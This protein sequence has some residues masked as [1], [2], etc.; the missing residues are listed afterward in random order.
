MRGFQ[1]FDH[2]GRFPP[3][4]RKANGQCRVRR[5][6][7]SAGYGTNCRS[8]QVVSDMEI[9]HF[10]GFFIMARRLLRLFYGV[11]VSDLSEF[12]HAACS[13]RGIGRTGRHKIADDAQTVVF[14]GNRLWSGFDSANRWSLSAAGRDEAGHG[15][16]ERTANI[17]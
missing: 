8:P 11:A 14:A 6:E 15:L 9:P 16:Y 7:I 4:T 10:T 2:C 1:T 5:A 13:G 17:A 3:N 12:S